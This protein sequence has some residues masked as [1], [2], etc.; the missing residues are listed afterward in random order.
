V[1]DLPVAEELVITDHMDI[2]RANGFRFKLDV[3]AAAGKRVSLT[4]VPFSKNTR[5]GEE[6]V[7]ELASILADR[8]GRMARLP[9]VRAMFASRACRSAIMI[10]RHLSIVS[11]TKLVAG[12][13]KLEQ[14][15]NCPHGRPTIRHLVDVRDVQFAS[16]S[17]FADG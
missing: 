5:F 12:M 10:G 6:D 16:R 2:F 1:L 4:A 14:P 13:T 11:M 8:P 9:R 15:W 7:H 3:D 17:A